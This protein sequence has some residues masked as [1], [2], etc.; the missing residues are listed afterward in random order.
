ML[1]LYHLHEIQFFMI[2][3]SREK[4]VYWKKKGLDLPEPEWCRW[5][6]KNDSILNCSSSLQQLLNTVKTS[7]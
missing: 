7:A 2:K 4:K 3:K 1:I 5:S 6:W